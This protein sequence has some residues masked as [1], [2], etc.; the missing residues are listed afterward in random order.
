M[1]HGERFKISKTISRIYEH[2]KSLTN[3]IQSSAKKKSIPKRKQQEPTNSWNPKKERQLTYW[4]CRRQLPVRCGKIKTLSR[5][6]TKFNLVVTKIIRW[7]LRFPRVLP[8][9]PKKSEIDRKKIYAQAWVFWP[10]EKICPNPAEW[11]KES[12]QVLKRREI[13][14]IQQERVYHL[15]LMFL[16]K[17]N[18]YG[19]FQSI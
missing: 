6:L 15:C 12:W 19:K 13:K 18:I 10:Q 4:V 17:I 9:Y 5:F 7:V 11:V 16:S 2:L 14:Y 3:P 8:K 1:S